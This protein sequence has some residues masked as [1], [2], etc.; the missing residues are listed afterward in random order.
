MD[1]LSSIFGAVREFFGF[2]K[3]REA[4]KNSP[5]QVANKI[6]ANDNARVAEIAREESAEDLTKL[7]NDVA[8]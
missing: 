8:E 1:L 2:A 5:A 6:A 7:R 3:Q 4:L